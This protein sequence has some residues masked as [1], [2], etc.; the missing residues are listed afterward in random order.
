[1]KACQATEAS[2]F[3]QLKRH[4]L[5]D[6]IWQMQISTRRHS[7]SASKSAGLLLL[8]LSLSS[9][10]QLKGTWLEIDRL[11]DGEL[12][13]SYS[14]SQKSLQDLPSP[15]KSEDANILYPLAHRNARI[16]RLPERPTLEEAIEVMKASDFI[17]GV[18][19]TDA[20]SR[21]GDSIRF[22]D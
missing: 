20:D 14:Y 11:A 3:Q 19:C 2:Q 9:T 21:H 5:V 16:R 6:K 17:A 4:F 22:A 18:P 8:P 15:A 7:E 10:Y 13:T 12:L 1:M